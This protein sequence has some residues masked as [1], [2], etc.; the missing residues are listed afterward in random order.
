MIQWSISTRCLLGKYVGVMDFFLYVDHLFVNRPLPV[1][2]LLK[3]VLPLF[4]SFN[5]HVPF[6]GVVSR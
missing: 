4:S 1:S 3:F 5:L 2:G 6:E